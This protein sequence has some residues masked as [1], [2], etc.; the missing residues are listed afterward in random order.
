M[1][2]NWLKYENMKAQT[3]K[4]YSY[5]HTY[6]WKVNVEAYTMDRNWESILVY[7]SKSEKDNKVWIE[8]VTYLDAKINSF[9]TYD[10][11]INASPLT[12]KPIDYKSQAPSDLSS[13]SYWSDYIDIRDLYQE[14]PIIRKYKE[15]AEIKES[16]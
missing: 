4:N 10:K 8:N 16:E 11:Q 9:W 14:N 15:L 2:L 1:D 13:K 7:F 3:D 12:A 6:L 5:E